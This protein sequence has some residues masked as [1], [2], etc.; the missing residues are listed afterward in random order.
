M[1]KHVIK[2]VRKTLNQPYMVPVNNLF[3]P[4]F[5]GIGT[6]VTLHRVV[7]SSEDFICEDLEITTDYL[8]EIINY[9]IKNNYE[10]V[11]LDIAHEIITGKIKTAKKFAVITFDDGYEDNYSLAYPIFKK[12]NLPFTIYVTTSFPDKTA[13]LWWYALKDLT[14]RKESIKFELHGI[15]YTFNTEVLKENAYSAIRE[16]IMSLNIKQQ[17]V[18]WTALFEE[19]GIDIHQYSQKLT[20]SWEQIK[21]LSQDSIVTI[22]AHTTNHFNLKALDAETARKEILDS[23]EKLETM[24]EAKVDHFAFPFGTKNEAGS[25]EFE[26]AGKMNF[27]T[28]TTTRCG[29]I[30]PEHS[31]HLSSLPRIV[32]SP[33]LFASF[34]HSYASG[35]FPALKHRFKRV[36]TY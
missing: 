6:I 3:S 12:Y 9:F 1:K 29:N 30:F 19:N 2:H 14:N 28:C 8:E 10:I 11:S 13:L 4:F 23:K 34:P 16:L 26:I 18:L 27:K 22:G 15:N 33:D 20:M 7:A 5:S 21:E 32:P 31:N 17:K 24:I 25:R 36:I 35:F